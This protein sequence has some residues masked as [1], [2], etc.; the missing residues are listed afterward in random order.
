MDSEA[1]TLLVF[2]CIQ[3][4]VSGVMLGLAGY[5]YFYNKTMP[6][7]AYALHA[8]AIVMFAGL[9]V[10]NVWEIIHLITRF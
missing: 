9:F 2:N 7:Y 10:L 6:T 1:I 8:I 3:L 5:N 4:L